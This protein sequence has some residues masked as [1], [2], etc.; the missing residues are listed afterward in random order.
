M[1]TSSSIGKSIQLQRKAAGLTQEQLAQ[2]SK[3][4]YATLTKIE[5]GVIKNPSVQ[6]VTRLVQ[7]LGLSLDDL[8]MV[9]QVSGKLALR[10][11]WEDVL[12][13]LSRGDSMY[14]SGIDE[15]LYLE[16]D[17]EGLKRFISDIKRRG[18][19]QLLI[20]CA[21]DTFGLPG[22]HLEYR[23]IPK[24]YFN[25]TP[26]YCYADR[27][28]TIIWGPPLQVVI[29]KNA[30]LADAYKKQFLFLWEHAQ[31]TSNRTSVATSRRRKR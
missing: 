1:K 2:K 10:R 25:P 28:A 17:R 12:E 5:S 26:I 4:P 31:K 18:I 20:S 3:V 16:A 27:V 14:I 30:H 21:G 22:E 15:R 19:G 24:R 11:I 23:W 8:L 9:E 29:L 13:T 7:T 6:V